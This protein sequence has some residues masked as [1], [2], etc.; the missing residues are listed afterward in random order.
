MTFAYNK[1]YLLT[2]QKVLGSML[3]YAVNDLHYTLNDFYKKFLDSQYSLLFAHGSPLVTVGCSGIELAWKV[4][5]NDDYEVDNRLYKEGKSVEYW[6]GYS[7]AYF[8]C[9]S[10]LSFQDIEALIPI[11]EIELMYYPYHEMDITQFVDAMEELYNDRKKQ[12]NL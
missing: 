2:A 9:F 4:L 6:C 5:D 3:D 1:L 8:Q 11:S 7:L 10:N 12:T